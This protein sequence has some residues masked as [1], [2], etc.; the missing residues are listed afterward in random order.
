MGTNS[1]KSGSPHTDFDEPERCKDSLWAAWVQA[2]MRTLRRCRSD[3]KT[4]S[5]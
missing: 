4:R 1:R 3:D 2:I 5:P